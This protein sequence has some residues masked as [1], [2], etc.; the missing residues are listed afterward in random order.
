MDISF[1]S[2]V[3]VGLEFLDDDD[4]SYLL[5]DFFIIRFLFIKEKK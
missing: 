1:V 3:M 2:G 5:V 4:F